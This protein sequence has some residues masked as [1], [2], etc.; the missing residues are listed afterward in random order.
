M[1]NLTDNLVPV[2]FISVMKRLPPLPAMAQVRCRWRLTE[3]T[4]GI[5][6]VANN[7]ADVAGIQSNA[8]SV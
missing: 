7:G 8:A 6:G 1:V 2:I 5:P 4:K 3:V